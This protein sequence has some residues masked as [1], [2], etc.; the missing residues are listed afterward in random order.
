MTVFFL[1]FALLSIGSAVMVITRTSPVY[2]ALFLVLTLAAQAGLFTMLGAFFIGM[3]QLLVYAGAIMVLFAFII[4][5]VDPGTGREII[6]SRVTWIIGGATV[7]LL[8]AQL[9]YALWLDPA[10]RSA[11]ADLTRTSELGSVESIGQA[12]FTRYLVPFEI[13]TVL[14]LVTVIGAVILA[15]RERRPS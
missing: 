13:G 5:T 7:L 9:I 11:A 10:S 3:L 6:R 14:L 1:L 15:A 4:M 12:L 8:A 2:A